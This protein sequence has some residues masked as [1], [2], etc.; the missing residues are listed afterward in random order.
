MSE[1]FNTTAKVVLTVL[2]ASQASSQAG[3]LASQKN[4]NH[5]YNND[6]KATITSIDHSLNKAPVNACQL[7]GFSKKID[8][9][10]PYFANVI[11]TENKLNLMFDFYQASGYGKIDKLYSIELQNAVLEKIT[12]LYPH[13]SDS[14]K[15]PEEMV[16][17]TYE[18]IVW[19]HHKETVLNI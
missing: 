7:F 14:F 4:E 5:F 6:M 18:Q 13:N 8:K 9:L 3:T 1:Y 16:H 19:H 15:S 11:S 17:V 12:M 10:T 2:E